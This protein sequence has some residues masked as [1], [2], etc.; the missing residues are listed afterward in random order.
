MNNLR[1]YK[2]IT[3]ISKKVGGPENLC[4]LL[5]G[6]GILVGNLDR[7]IKYFTKNSKKINTNTELPVFSVHSEFLD[8]HGAHLQIDDQF[9][10]LVEDQNSILIEII[11][12]S[13]NPYFVEK[14][15]LFQISNFEVN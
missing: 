10:V 8:K 3:V 12:D 4:I 7:V 1:G 14:D 9:R 2:T 13:N 15:V 5:I 6:A 11:N